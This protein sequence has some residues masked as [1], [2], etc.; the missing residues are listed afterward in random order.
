MSLFS[1]A[2][3]SFGRSAKNLHPP[4]SARDGPCSTDGGE[5]LPYAPATLP[6]CLAILQHHGFKFPLKY[7]LALEGY[8]LLEPPRRTW[9]VIKLARGQIIAYI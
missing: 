4:S 8:E 2:H 3:R 6:T 7:G 5:R 1:T 9:S